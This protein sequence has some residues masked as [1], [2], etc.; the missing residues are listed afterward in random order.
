MSA[1]AESGVRRRSAPQ[2][3]RILWLHAEIRDDRAPNAG[4][5][6][7]RFGVS[8]RTA[9]ADIAFLRDR[10]EAPLKYEGRRRGF[11]YTDPSFALPAMILTEGELLALFLAEEVTH[12]YLGTPLESALRTAV[13]KIRRSLPEEAGVR[14]NEAAE[15]FRFRGGSSVV[16]PLSVLADFRRAIVEQRPVRMLYYSPKRDETNEREIEP[17]FLENVRGDWMVAAWDHLRERPLTFMLCRIREYELG[18][19][20]FRR[21]PE[22]E[23]EAF[24]RGA[25][26]TERGEALREVV[27]RFDALQARWI[28]ERGW[29]PSQR[30]EEREDGGLVL[31]LT[32]ASE[33]DLVRWVLG[34]GRHV[35]VLE[36]AEL[37]ERVAEELRAAAETYR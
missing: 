30:I 7:E 35:E 15:L 16:V 27:L 33:D 6:T 11:V 22:L 26:L 1:H 2:W 20:R 14:L 25:F 9:R 21:R 31:R 34:Y 19:R 13:E 10:L 3:E 24:N 8:E 29:H 23:P 28:R 17:H 12:Q 18:E 37:R 36:P 32:V 4:K 5:L